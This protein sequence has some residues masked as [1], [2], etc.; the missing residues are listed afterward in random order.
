MSYLIFKNNI[1]DFD[2]NILDGDD[3]AGELKRIKNSVPSD[4][5]I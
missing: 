4:S 2:M 5:I 1:L 3:W